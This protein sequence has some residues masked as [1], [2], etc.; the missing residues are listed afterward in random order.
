MRKERVFGMPVNTG[1]GTIVGE[2]IPFIIGVVVVVLLLIAALRSYIT[3]RLPPADWGFSFDVDA[4]GRDVTPEEVVA[5]MR[6]SA[7]RFFDAEMFEKAALVSLVTVIFW[8]ILPGVQA[9]PVSISGGVTIVIVANTVISELL[10]RYGVRWSSTLV[11][12][13]VMAIVN[14]LV[15]AA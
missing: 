7:Q 4:H 15:V 6:I 8:R 13:A 3:N 5:A 9:S 10:V 1:W 12:F 2:S 11:E 14:A